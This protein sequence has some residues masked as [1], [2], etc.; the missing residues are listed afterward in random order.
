MD[1]ET[2]VKTYADMVYKIAF[3]YAA[4]PTD[5]DDIF[6]ETFLKYFKKERTFES[7][8]HRKAWLI[9][10]TVNCAK[11]FLGSRTPWA[12]L[13]EAITANPAEDRRD[14]HMDLRMAIDSL[15]PEYR[16]VIL[17]HY[18]EDLSVRQIAQILDRNENTVKIH[19][20]RARQKLK[21]FLE[22]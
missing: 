5:A 16:E 22:E 8:E 14:L 18:M 10:V 7:E 4:N 17:L 13:N 12:E 6:S 21:A 3:R 15:R 9:R 19:L 2:V 1:E 11:D 20:S